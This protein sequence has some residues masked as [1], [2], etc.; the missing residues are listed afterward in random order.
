MVVVPPKLNLTLEAPLPPET[1]VGEP[2]F[3]TLKII[4]QGT[5][6]VNFTGAAVEADNAEV[7]EGAEQPMSPLRTDDET[8]VAAGVIPSEEG[9]VTVRIKLNYTDDLNKPQT[10]TQTYSLPAVIPPTPEPIDPG[11]DPFLPPVNGFDGETDG[12]DL[13][14]RLLLGLLG[15]GS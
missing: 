1:N 11:I 5:K 3:L 4:N 9:E 7:I 14:G 13:L 12:D 2:L 8:T 10:I 6:V 15:L